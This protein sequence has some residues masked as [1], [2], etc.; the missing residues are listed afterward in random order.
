MGSKFPLQAG[1]A[2]AV[3]RRRP[4]RMRKEEG[5][6]PRLNRLTEN[7]RRTDDA[8]RFPAGAIQG[9][10]DRLPDPTGEASTPCRQE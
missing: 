1:R 2:P 8:V 3:P 4:W 9:D 6:L 7:I 5:N 10:L